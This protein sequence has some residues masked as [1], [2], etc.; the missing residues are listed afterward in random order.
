MIARLALTVPLVACGGTSDGAKPGGGTSTRATPAAP[1][2]LAMPALGVD[3]VRKLNYVY[4]DGAKDY[5]KVTAALKATPRDWA[6]VRAAA[7][8]TLAKDADHL[9]ARWALGKALANTGEPD[10]ATTALTA[11]LAGDWL[12]WGPGLADDPDLAAYLATPPGQALTALST[13]MGAAVKAAIASEPLI[14]ARRSTWKAPKPGTSYAA[15]RGELYAV[16]LAS[17]R[18]LRVT[19]TDHTLAGFVR[20]PSGELLLAGFSQAQVPPS[21]KAMT[22]APLLTRAW[23]RA[24]SPTTLSDASARAS[25]GKARTIWVGYGAGE[26]IVVET[27]AASGRWNPGKITSYVVDRSTGKLTK[28]PGGARLEPSLQLA[29]DDVG[30][31]SAPTFPADLDAK[32]AD[33]LAAVVDVDERGAPRLA[34][35]AA[36]PTGAWLAFASA[37]DPCA[38]GDDAPKPSLYVADAKTGTYK[39][40]LTA[41]SRFGLQW[42]DADRLLYEDGTGGLRVFDAAAGRETG[43]LG[44]RAGMALGALAPSAAPLCRTEPV[45]DD[46]DAVDDVPTDE[47]DAPAATP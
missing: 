44:E 5:A 6:A 33:K 46:P 14:L 7:E 40:V 23:V 19:H 1:A 45:V 38:K 16:D 30:P 27:A 37:T 2:E 12:A 39:H 28:G 31:A 43:K 32:L 36:S 42:I 3:A 20:A 22:E 18:Y 34:A 4:G 9:D 17:K 11:A 35:V 13:K 15:T 25:V 47:G 24:F 41:A 21:A 10:L 26:Q 8:A 29:L